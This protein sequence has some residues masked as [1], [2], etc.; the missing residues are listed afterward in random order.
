[1]KDI[2][3]KEKFGT[4]I[5]FDQDRNLFYCDY[6]GMKYDN[7]N[8]AELEKDIQKST[9]KPETGEYFIKGYD[10]IRKVRAVRSWIDSFSGT[11][12]VYVEF[13]KKTAGSNHDTVERKNLYPVNE[14]NKELYKKGEELESK[15]WSL[16]WE[17]RRTMDEL[18]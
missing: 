9:I 8:L 15:G 16:I 1:M 18:T 14:K 7:T 13:I 11:E 4:T 12:E 3:I 6:A 17:G 5:W 2:K 10:G